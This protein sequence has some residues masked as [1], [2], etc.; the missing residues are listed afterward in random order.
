[1]RFLFVI[2][3]TLM[4]SIAQAQLIPS[5]HFTTL[6]K[7]ESA[8]SLVWNLPAD[9]LEQT[10]GFEAIAWAKFNSGA[11]RFTPREV[12]NFRTINNIDLSIDAT[13]RHLI[14]TLQA[15]SA[16]YTDMIVFFNEIWRS[17]AFSIDWFK[18]GL[19]NTKPRK[20]A[21][22]RRPEQV[23]AVLSN[24]AQF[25][26]NKAKLDTDATLAR[27]STK[28]DLL[29]I[30]SRDNVPLDL[31]QDVA[32]GLAPP[33]AHKSTPAPALSALPKGVIYVPDPDASETMIFI[34]EA[35]KLTND[36]DKALADTLYKYM[37]YGPGSEM[38]RIIRQQERAAY[39]PNL[40]FDRI[41]KDWFVMGLSATVAAEEW[42]RIYQLIADIYTK[43][44][45]GKNTQQGLLDSKDHMLGTTFYSLRNNAAWLS[46]RI[47]ELHPNG[48]PNGQINLPELS[49]RFDM[50]IGMINQKARDVIAPI[51]DL[52]I[53]IMGGD[54][55]P[56]AVLGAKKYCILDI[57]AWLSECLAQL[58]N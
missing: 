38:F 37:G 56:K 30:N 12:A 36:N 25:R 33:R 24:Y 8:L 31:A 4:A 48:I 3:C 49:A 13:G 39:A 53:I 54:I 35:R 6:N 41:Y 52:L 18:R 42:P 44:R 29:I 20:Q 16:N 45:L 55:D 10:R 22:F 11:G 27:I 7:G 1:M 23:V 50:D 34:G 17:D 2:L 5:L 26:Q 57:D 58:E 51:D 32:D 15:P 9:S 46:A 43:A 19:H 47:M 21:R 14:I 28:P 40:H